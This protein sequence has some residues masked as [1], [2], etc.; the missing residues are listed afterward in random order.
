NTL[1]TGGIGAS[2]LG[3]KQPNPNLNI[4]GATGQIL[5]ISATTGLPNG[6]NLVNLPIGSILPGVVSAGTAGIAFGIVGS[7]LNLNLALEAL[8]RGGKTRPLARPQIV[9]VE[10]HN[11][12]LRL[13]EEPPSAPASS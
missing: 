6:G 10:H 5:P 11:A 8:T 12:T 4:G 1:T 13:G 9:T 2:E 3:G 7:R